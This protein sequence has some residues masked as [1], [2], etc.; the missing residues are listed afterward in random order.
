MFLVLFVHLYIYYVNA[1]CFKIMICFKEIPEFYKTRSDS[2]LRVMV[3]YNAL[4]Y[5]D[6]NDLQ[7]CRYYLKFNGHECTEPGTIEG[8]SAI[9][10][11]IAVY[12]SNISMLCYVLFIVFRKFKLFLHNLTKFQ[13]IENQL[14]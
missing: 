6:D 1:D 4:A 11:N 13:I 3:S 7:C 12:Q 5:S 14:T 10:K 9:N 2:G 8:A